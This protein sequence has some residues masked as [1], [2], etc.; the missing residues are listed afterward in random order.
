[1]SGEESVD[2]CLALESSRVIR[3]SADIPKATLTSVVGSLCIQNTVKENESTKL[4]PLALNARLA[5][6]HDNLAE[7]NESKRLGKVKINLTPREGFGWIQPAAALTWEPSINPEFEEYEKT[8]ASLVR[9][10]AKG[11]KHDAKSKSE[12]LKAVTLGLNKC[13]I[14]DVSFSSEISAGILVALIG[15][16]DVESRLFT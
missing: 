11:G 8:L 7:I 2:V 1:M 4:N 3:I 13:K 6:D 5:L 16:F 9:A 15:T 12:F 14:L 10:L